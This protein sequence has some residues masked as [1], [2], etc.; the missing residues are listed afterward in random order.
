MS[1]HTPSPIVQVMQ[2]LKCCFAEI[3]ILVFI[4]EIH[5]IC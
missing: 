3:L 1:F 5:S 4:T 2:V